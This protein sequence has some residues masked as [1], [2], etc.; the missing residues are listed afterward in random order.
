MDF[1]NALAE[2]PLIAIL[3]GMQPDEA[4]KACEAHVVMNVVG[5]VAVTQWLAG[6]TGLLLGRIYLVA[7]A[8][9]SL[10]IW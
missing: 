4:R 6:D 8:P 10:A 1:D 2:L 5:I 7:M 3:R 9:I